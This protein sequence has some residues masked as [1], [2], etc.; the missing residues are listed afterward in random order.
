MALRPGKYDE[1]GYYFPSSLQY[2]NGLYGSD[3]TQGTDNII[4]IGNDSSERVVT[5]KAFIEDFQ[6]KL[7]K[8]TEQI[9]INTF[10]SRNQ[11]IENHSTIG[12]TVTLNVPAH[13]F[14]ESRNN[15]AKIVELQKMIAPSIYKVAAD[16]VNDAHVSLRVFFKNLLNS[17]EYFSSPLTLGSYSELKKYGASVYCLN[18]KYDPDLDMG[19]F[20][21]PDNP[22]DK[23]LYPK[24][25]KLS[26]EL[27]IIHET[28]SADGRTYIRGFTKNGIYRHDDKIYTPFNVPIRNDLGEPNKYITKQKSNIYQSTLNVVNN[29]RDGFIFISNGILTNSGEGVTTKDKIYN[30]TG[31]YKRR[32]YVVFANFIDSFSRDV[33]FEKIDLTE[34]DKDFSSGYSKSKYANV[35]YNLSFNAAATSIIEAKNNLG[36]LQILS[37]LVSKSMDSKF[38]KMATTKDVS[39]SVGSVHY[40]YD[41]NKTDIKIYVPGLIEKPGAS[42][43][44]N[45]YDYSTSISNSLDLSIITCD[46]K[47][48]ME[49]GFF[50]EGG[51]LYPKAY[52][53]TISLA[54]KDM[55][56]NENFAKV[57]VEGKVENSLSN[58]EYLLFP[59][60]RKYTRITKGG[61]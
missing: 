3:G 60:N 2:P 61:K 9:K 57:E 29:T 20:D 18:M 5:L 48:H 54:Q 15:L 41:N 35:S 39:D 28:K 31:T 24:N 47:F 7:T 55:S 58:E 56:M 4:Y 30:T 34:E 21:A 16:D 44:L 19:F 59:F 12:F 25:I 36:K 33:K 14:N 22:S 53:V 46:I 10:G 43:T 32:R 23:Y 11:I 1:D 8:N 40:T 51:K 37:R 45:N 26:M 42:R 52:S 17:G 6:Y 13:S 50:D 38:I 49:M 27:N